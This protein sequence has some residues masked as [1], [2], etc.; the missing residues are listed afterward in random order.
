MIFYLKT[1]P[2]I[3][4]KITEINKIHIPMYSIKLL[5]I[6]ELLLRC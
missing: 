1:F 6:N 5:F 3:S 2:I 4:G